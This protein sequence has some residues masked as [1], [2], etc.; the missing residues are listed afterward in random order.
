VQIHDL[1]TRQV[2]K[3]KLE[4]PLK[5]NEKTLMWYPKEFTV[6]AKDWQVVEGLHIYRQ[7]V[8]LDPTPENKE[9][10]KMLEEERKAAQEEERRE[11]KRKKVGLNR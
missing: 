6:T 9:A 2:F 11:R 3:A 5:P 1:D 10:L 8:T 7:R 4:V